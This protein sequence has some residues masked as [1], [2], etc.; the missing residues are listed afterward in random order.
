MG[1]TVKDKVLSYVVPFLNTVRPL[2][3]PVGLAAAVVT[4]AI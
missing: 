2:P 1:K 3:G 4:S